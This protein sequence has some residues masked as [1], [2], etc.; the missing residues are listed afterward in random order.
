MCRNNIEQICN[1]FWIL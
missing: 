1:L